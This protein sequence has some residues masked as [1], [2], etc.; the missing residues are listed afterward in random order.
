VLASAERLASAPANEELTSF[1]AALVSLLRDGDQHAPPRLTLDTV[2]ARLVARLRLAGAP[3]PR[4][5]SG[6]Q[7]GARAGVDSWGL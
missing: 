4:R 7:S 6:D 3:M 1:S 2:Y 5:Q